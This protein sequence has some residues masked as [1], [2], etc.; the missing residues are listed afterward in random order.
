[1]EHTV[2]SLWESLLG[3]CMP[4]DSQWLLPWDVCALPSLFFKTQSRGN[5][6]G[7]E[8]MLAVSC[9]SSLALCHSNEEVTDDAERDQQLGLAEPSS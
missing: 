5:R 6:D 4:C 9:R 8:K 3:Q 2:S 7:E 1:M